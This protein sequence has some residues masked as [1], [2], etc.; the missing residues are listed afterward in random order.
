[1]AVVKADGY[2]HGAVEVARAALD[3]GADRLGVAIPEEGWELREAGIAV[4]ILVFGLIQPEE[5]YKVVEADLDQTVCSVE[6][7]QTLDR[8]AARASKRINVHIKVDTGMGRIGLTPEEVVSF[9]RRVQEFKNLNLEG[10]FS[11][12]ATADAKDKTFA[13]RQLELFDGVLRDLE[14][15]DIDIP[16]RHMANS[17]AILDLPGSYYDMVR[18]GIMIYGLYPSREVSRS[19]ELRPAMTLQTKVVAVKTVPRGTPISYGRTFITRAQATVIATLPIGYADGLSRLLSNKGEVLIR[20]RRA[21]LVGTICMDMCMAD[22][23]SV[24]GVRCGDEAIIFGEEPP[25]DEVAEK[26]GT[27]NY[28]VT[29]AVSRRVPRV[30]MG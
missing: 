16:I 8:E 3:S 6:L 1:M 24:E 21:P 15:A 30:Y 13:Q 25:V 10:I 22:V 11:H 5:A 20:G 17:A 23:S 4:P 12:F 7:L 27:I 28:E 2:G 9:A 26:I 19:I 29:C 18:P 14:R